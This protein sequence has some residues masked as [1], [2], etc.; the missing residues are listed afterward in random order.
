MW[1]DVNTK[2]DGIGMRRIFAALAGDRYEVLWDGLE[3]I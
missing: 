2:G 1:I 3:W